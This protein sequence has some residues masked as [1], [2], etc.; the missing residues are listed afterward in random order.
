MIRAFKTGRRSCALRAVHRDVVSRAFSTK[1]F[2]ET[3]MNKI[4][5]ILSILL[6]AAFIAACGSGTTGT[7]KTIK[8]GPIGNLTVTIASSDGVL[9]K[10]K[11]QLILTFADS[12]GK[13]V[14]VGSASL[15]FFMPAMGSM[16]AMN[17]PAT[18]TTTPTP[19]MYW[20]N[21]DIE[22][23]GEWQAQVAFDGPA[24]KGKGTIAVTAQ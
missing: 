10:G 17:S 14:D 9:K 3:F 23:T 15:N 22:M 24:G 1:Y 20:A 2:E 5:T 11:Q 6:I 4:I 21:V 12:S 18:L 8:S 13:P 16:A 7:G 19:G